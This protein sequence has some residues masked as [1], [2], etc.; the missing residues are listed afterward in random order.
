[1]SV[2]PVLAGTDILAGGGNIDSMASVSLDQLI[3]DAELFGAM[4][5][6]AR[7]M[8]VDPDELG[9]DAVHAVGP[10][11]HF[12]EH[13]HTLARYRDAFQT[14]LVFDRQFRDVWRERGS[15][16]VTQK[17]HELREQILVEH[18]V[19]PLSESQRKQIDEVLSEA[20]AKATE[21]QT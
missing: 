7:G 8:K 1:M 6:M 21:V 5:R 15:T 13:D 19:P 12:L 17:A 16:T 20:A 9:L 10:R 11:R 14:P 3:V 4:K 2:L 18:A